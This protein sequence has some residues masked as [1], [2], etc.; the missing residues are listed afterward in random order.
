[1]KPFSARNLAGGRRAAAGTGAASAAAALQTGTR[2]C[3]QSR[4]GRSYGA[5]SIRAS[6]FATVAT[7][8]LAWKLSS[9][10]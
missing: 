2:T 6:R 4:A 7:V 9:L 5:G 10:S 3:V 8:L 1:M